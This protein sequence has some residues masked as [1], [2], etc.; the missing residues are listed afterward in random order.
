MDEQKLSYL[1]NKISDAELRIEKQ[2]N[3][4]SENLTPEET[5]WMLSDLNV[6]YKQLE[7]KKQLYELFLN[8][9]NR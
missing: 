6:F 8:G 4:I 7:H 5:Y 1:K 9:Y 3:L 2:K